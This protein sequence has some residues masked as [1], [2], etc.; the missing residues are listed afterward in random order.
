MIVNY[1]YAVNLV[2]HEHLLEQDA[3]MHLLVGV[4]RHNQ[5]AIG[6]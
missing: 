1:R 5:N 4:N 2:V 3:Q 6:L